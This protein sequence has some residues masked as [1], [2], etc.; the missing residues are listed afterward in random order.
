MT[1][2]T[3][4]SVLSRVMSDAEHQATKLLGANL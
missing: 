2:K 4:T 3:M 1:H